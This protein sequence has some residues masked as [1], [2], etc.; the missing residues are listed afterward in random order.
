LTNR[1]E[2]E[3]PDS[4]ATRSAGRLHPRDRALRPTGTSAHSRWR[5]RPSPVTRALPALRRS[6]SP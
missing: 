2:V 6:T 4:A 5:R 3:M 1:E